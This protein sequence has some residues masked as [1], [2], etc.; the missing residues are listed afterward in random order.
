MPTYTGTSGND[1][2]TVINPG[3]FTLD[4]LGG[5][6]TLYLGTSLRTD[7]TITKSGDG[8]VHIDSVSGASAKLHATLY[9]ME[10]LVFNNKRDTLDLA[11]YFGDTTPPTVTITDNVPGTGAGNITYALAFSENVTGLTASDFTVANGSVV[12]VSGSGASYSVVVAPNAGTEGT[13]SLTLRAASVSDAAGNANAAA[14]TAAAQ[15]IDTKGPTVTA[16]TP[17][18]SATEVEVGANIV[19]TFNEAIQRGAGAIVLRDASGAAVASWDAATSA[20]LAVA[21]NVLTINPSAD[22]GAGTGYRVEFPAGSLKDLAGNAWTGSTALQFSTA[23]KAVQSFVG[24]AANDTFTVP[25]GVSTADGQGGIDKLVFAQPRGAYT[26]KSTATGFVV[27]AGDGSITIDFS[28]I[29]RL[30]F[31]DT[32]LALDLNGNAGLVAKVLGAVFGAGAVAQAD[33]VGIGLQLADSGSSYAGLMQLALD[34]RLGAGA[35]H[36]AVV[37]LLWGNIVGGAP[38][39]GDEAYYVSLL[40]SNALTPA[41]LGVLAAETDFNLQ[42]IDLVGLSQSGLP[43]IGG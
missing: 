26:L 43:Y 24:T 17:V 15:P 7:Y 6:D 33:Y 27:N 39:A 31:S 2:W 10:T 13:L 20:N 34:A 21:G 4:G 40:D 11:T 22:L 42:R 18:V 19:I 29:E 9:N 1:S 8:A 32:K 3:T 41:A 12:S 23:G 16:S 5:A 37:D 28:H 36:K 25:V 14:T 38:S 30:Q 35:S